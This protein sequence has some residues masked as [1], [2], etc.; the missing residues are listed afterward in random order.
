MCMILIQWCYFALIAF[1]TGFTALFL[2]ERRFGYRVK[3][4]VSVLMAGLLTLNVY[5]QYFSLFSGV[6]LRA[7]ALLCA[8]V[9]MAAV[10]LRKRIKNFLKQ[11]MEE[12]GRGRLLLYGFLVLLF[13]YGSSRGYMHYDTGL[14]HAQSIR[15][16][17]E[18][19][20]VPGLANLHSRF[21]YNSAAFALC[22][23]FG[24]AGL[25]KYPM[26]CVQGFF[27]LLCAVKCTALL[28]LTR[29]KRVLV[30]DFLSAGCVFY[31]VAVFR[32]LV[33]PASD[34]FAMLILFFVVITWAQLLERREF[35][36]VP[37][38]LLSL[39]LVYG[40]TVKLS[41][42][43]MLV[44]A[45]YPGILLI[46]QRKWGQIA[47]YIGLGVFIALPWLA[48]NAMISG[49]LF[50]PFTFPDLFDVDWKISKGY[51]DSDAAEIQVYAKEI[52]DVYQKDMPFSGWF[53]NWLQA[54]TVLDRVLVGCAWLAVPVS[55]LH[56]MAV[57]GK[58]VGARLSGAAGKKGRKGAPGMTLVGEN[59]SCWAFALLEAAA[60]LGFLIWQFGAPL[61]R[62]GYFF[63]LFLPL[64][65]FGGLYARFFGREGGFRIFAG[66][67]VAFLL[68]RGYN[69]GNMV[70]ELWREPW[71]V[72]QQDYGTW[73]AETYQVDGVTIYVPLDRGQ[74]GY[75]K[76]PS[77]PVVQPIELRDGK[78]IESGFRQRAAGNHAG[79]E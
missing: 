3:S 32:E 66:L 24:G 69:L 28:D 59:G 7:N 15:W 76:F 74:I 73:P 34:Y 4:A 2:F 26:H 21:G 79:E 38:A 71:Y 20:V 77:S 16:I 17:E 61:V 75:D 48:R 67:L 25:T 40:A 8:F 46:R 78:A 10:V 56:L 70:L 50:Y 36:A 31:L 35:S 6:G 44:L 39:Y 33:S 55:V 30:S 12:T 68:Y 23:L 47:C 5:A 64:V 18:Y 72:Y 54:Q 13:A 9:L 41:A 53:P 49:W 45:L 1:V 58:R 57:A 22:A 63:V 11:K 62:Y 52:F 65:A 19:G 51:A 29:R 60:L 43:G 37:Y 14:Y 42:A 27:A